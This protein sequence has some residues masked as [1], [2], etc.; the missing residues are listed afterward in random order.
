MSCLPLTVG[1]HLHQARVDPNLPRDVGSPLL[2]PWGRG[3]SQ[4][5][6]AW[7]GFIYLLHLFI[8]FCYMACRG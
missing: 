3:A 4:C 1:Q 5:C 6:S 7:M 8:Y 2:L